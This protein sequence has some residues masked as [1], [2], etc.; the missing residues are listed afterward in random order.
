MPVIMLATPA[1][2]AARNGCR[3]W[4]F[5]WSA[6]TSTI[7]KASAVSVVVRPSPGKCLAHANTPSAWLASIHALINVAAIRGSACIARV[8]TTG[9]FPK[10]SKSQTGAK[11]QF[12]PIVRASR[13]VN[14]A[15]RRN[16]SIS[17][18]AAMAASGGSP[19]AP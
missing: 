11:F 8:P 13:A 10:P 14:R 16:D 19:V 3:S 17:P 4:S 15:A 1:E 12:T 18:S 7:G 5:N 9:L 2:I 6:E